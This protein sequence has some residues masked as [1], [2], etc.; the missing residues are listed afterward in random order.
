MAGFSTDRLITAP[1][2]EPV[3]VADLRAHLRIV[4]NGEDAD[5]QAY[6]K[7]AREYIEGQTCR[8]LVTQTRETVMDDFT[9]CSIEFGRSPLVTIT[10]VKYLDTS[11]SEQTLATSV[12]YTDTNTEPGSIILKDGQAWPVVGAVPSAVRIRY[13]AGTTADAVT[14]GIK[15]AILFLAAWFYE[16]RT[17]VNF[18]NIVNELPHTLQAMIWANRV[19]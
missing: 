1:S 15:Q 13:T 12:Y 17:P 18:G 4:G 3:G 14:P 16:T 9:D 7:A 19:F 8:A 5:L 10:S 2:E 6:G 11:L